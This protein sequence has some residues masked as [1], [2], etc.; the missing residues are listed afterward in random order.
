MSIC[1]IIS[2]SRRN[3]P[4]LSVKG[5]NAAE[6]YQVACR[7]NKWLHAYAPEWAEYRDRARK[8]ITYPDMFYCAIPL[9]DKRCTLTALSITKLLQAIAKS[10]VEFD[11]ISNHIGYMSCVEF[12]EP[13]P[14]V[15]ID[16][17]LTKSELVDFI[18]E[19]DGYQVTTRM[20]KAELLEIAH[21]I[22]A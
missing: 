11:F 17:S 1:I 5:F 19:H 7:V 20:R 14:Q 4:V 9:T 12:D 10:G 2:Q 21:A 13:Q 22:L 8:D 16:P 3:T 15:N 18:N 6:V